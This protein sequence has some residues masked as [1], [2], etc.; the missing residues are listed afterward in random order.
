MTDKPDDEMRGR[1]GP[2]SDTSPR[3]SSERG[4][5]NFKPRGKP[6]FGKPS[7]G[8]KR[9]GDKPFRPRPPRDGEERSFKPRDGDRPFKPRGERPYGDR[10]S[11]DRPYS[12]RPRGDRPSGDRPYGDRPRGDRPS[13][14]RPFRPRPEGDRP[15][16]ARD[17]EERSFKPR[18][19]GDRPFRAREGGGGDRPF[20]PRGDRPSGD[21]PYGDRPRGDRPSGDRPY[22]DRPRGDRPSGDRPFRPR[23]EGGGDRPFKPRGDRPSGDRPYGDRP[24]GDRPFRPRPEGDR[25]YRARDGEERSF[26]PREGGD[27]PYRAREGGG[28]DRPYGDKPYRSRSDGDRPLRPRPQREEGSPR[29]ENAQRE[30]GQTNQMPQIEGKERIAKAMARAGVASRRDAEEMIAAGRV[31]LNGTPLT[32]P[33]ILVGPEDVV[34]VD[35]HLLP[36][37]EKTRMWLYNKPSGLVTTAHDPEGRPTV[38]DNLPEGLPRV[39][40]IG[41]LDINTEGLLLLTND[42]GL[43]QVLAHPRTGWMRRYRVRA[44]GEITPAQLDA[45]ADGVTIDEMHYGPIEARIDRT[46][47][48]NVW[49]TLGIR[50]GKNREVKRVL[51]HLGLQ[52]NRLIRLSFGPFQLGEI[53]EGMVEEVRTRVLKDQ[54]GRDLAAEAEVDFDLPS[55]EETQSESPRRAREETRPRQDRG[56]DRSPR[57]HDDEDGLTPDEIRAQ[58]WVDETPAP[59]AP[60]QEA[61]EHRPARHGGEPA[62]AVW[63][64]AETEG[65]RPNVARKPRRGD[66]PFAARSAS[67]TRE[68][69]RA[70]QVED[71]KGRKVK[72]ERIVSDREVDVDEPWKQAEAPRLYRKPREDGSS[73][74]HGERSFGNREGGKTDRGDRPFRPRPPRDGEE[75]SFR[76]RE[77]GGGGGFKPRE[78]GGE[79][80]YRSRD[81]GSDRP[82]RAP[83]AEDRPFRK[84][85]TDAPS[86]PSGDRPERSFRPRD[87]GDR[88]FRPRPP[89]DGEERAFKPREGGGSD[90]GYKPR[91]GGGFKPRDGG[92]SYGGRGGPKGPPRGGPRGPQRR[93]D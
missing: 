39:I 28:G 57:H 61:L 23:P 31:T 2:R 69:E 64:D 29:E 35:G 48:D 40:S 19:G 86:G 71:P 44:F 92:G 79:R 43:A 16:R 58:P 6:G 88:P 1:K 83:S 4:E 50:E 93:D 54:L 70:G 3:D 34:T 74:G 47:G 84:P 12:D 90:G 91:G 18:E 49:L 25:P 87:D 85:R 52:V 53:E 76:P 46:Q 38:F 42:G 63:R 41:R 56:R 78:G 22:G 66:D 77:G 32:T 17:G 72:V 55:G 10:P 7:F 15:Y 13:G 14:D 60:S 51:E 21:R 73:S 75:R 62:R 37:K 45:I 27:R 68:R 81:G 5:R 82:A 89:R 30:P 65:A 9:D 26:K 24:S 36:P 80:P 33:A 67:G 20:K 59:M 8:S 11:G